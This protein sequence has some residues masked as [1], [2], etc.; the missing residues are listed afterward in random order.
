MPFKRP[1]YNKQQEMQ[2]LPLPPYAF[3]DQDAGS[4]PVHGSPAF[5]PVTTT[6]HNITARHLHDISTG[7]PD[8]P[9]FIRSWRKQ[10]QD[11]LTQHNAKSIQ[12]LLAGGGDITETEMHKRCQEVL[13]KYSRQTW[14]FASS[15]REL[16]LPTDTTDA[17]AEIEREIGMSPDHLREAQRRAARM[18]VNSAKAAAVAETHLEEKLKRLDTV[19]GRINDLMFLESSPLLG[20]LE[21]PAHAYLNSVL[22]KI[23]LEDDYAELVTHYKKF[24]ILKNLLSLSAFQ[25]PATAIAP[26]CTICMTNE[27]TTAVTPCGHTFCDEC[28]R[29]QMTACYICRVQIRDKQRLY[30]N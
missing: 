19:T 16:S 2:G 28:C 13:G 9:K 5:G 8:D 23:R 25:R 29:N 18:Y 3:E 20:N 15:T 1:P 6:M 14:N 12:F 17:A 4:G 21:G 11:T 10:L 30:F 26:T 27:I 22:E 7:L 24:A